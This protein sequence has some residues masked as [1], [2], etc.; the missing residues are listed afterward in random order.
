[1]LSNLQLFT[2]Q[3]HPAHGM[4]SSWTHQVLIH[5]PSHTSHTD[6]D[7]TQP[8][9]QEQ[10]LLA[11]LHSQPVPKHSAHTSYI[12]CGGH[13]CPRLPPSPMDKNSCSSSYMFTCNNTAPHISA[14]PSK[15]KA[16]CTLGFTCAMLDLG[17]YSQWCL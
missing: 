2:D 15:H 1:M 7:N 16:C 13:P 14:W 5:P 8:W 9:Q 3:E 11:S 17:Y 10:A 12:L 6:P 4:P